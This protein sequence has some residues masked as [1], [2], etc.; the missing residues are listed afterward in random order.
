MVGILNRENV[1][2]V[3]LNFQSIDVQ[4]MI[5][6]YLYSLKDRNVNIIHNPKKRSA[7]SY[8]F[9]DCYP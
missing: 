5:H 9:T 1:L 3:F 4:R 6:K 7:I 8:H 2:I